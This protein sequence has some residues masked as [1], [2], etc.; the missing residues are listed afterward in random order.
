MLV[1]CALAA[2]AQEQIRIWQAGNDTRLNVPE[3]TFADGGAAFSAGGHTYSVNAVDSITVV[4][5]VTVTYSETTASVDLGHAPG[6][7]YTIDGA[8]VNILSTNSKNELEFVLQGQ[9]T[10]GSLT[11]DGPLK[12]RFYLNGLKLTSDRG[13][14]IDIQC[15]KRVALILNPGTENVLSD[16]ATG[17][18]KAAF[19]CKGHVEIEGSG[20][21]TVT[22]NA[23]HAIAT[24]E[25]LQLK[26]NTGTVTVNK[27][28][29]DAFHVGQ[30]FL[31][32][33]GT[34]NISGQGTDGIQ[35]ET[36]MAA[37]GVT[38]EPT[39]EENGNAF[40][41]GGRIN[42]TAVT[43]DDSKG[44]KM[45]GNMTVTG[46]TFIINATGAGTKGI[47]VGGN[48]LIN[49]DSGTTQMMIRAEGGRYVDPVNQEDSRCMGIKVKGNLTINAGTV[50]VSNTG[51]GS[52][53][54]K[55]DGVYTKS[56]AASVSA[57]VA[58]GQ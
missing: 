16:A 19:Y 28:V 21:L 26:K 22:G 7:T 58:T 31:M 29:S 25:Y 4:H 10:Q 17:L 27:S 56:D 34:V 3:M 53:G 2:Q 47:S 35:V 18:Q 41:N 42:I 13:A 57:N 9:S 6:V 48:M 15:G 20:S 55:V 45:S 23:R 50:R 51:S 54:I 38:P 32:N 52:R 30:Y 8:H 46:G 1:L 37:D 24:K 5:T 39:K 43:G 11:Y 49:Q 12:C 44:I 14:A 33:G 40:V 36:I